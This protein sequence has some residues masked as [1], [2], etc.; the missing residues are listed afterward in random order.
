M[1]ATQKIQVGMIHAGKTVTV[2]AEDSQFPLVIDDETVTAV[3]RATTSEIHSYKAYATKTPWLAHPEG[4]KPQSP[5]SGWTPVTL[6]SSPNCCNSSPAGRPATP[7]GSARRW[8]VMSAIPPTAPRS[9]AGTWTGS[10]S[11]S[12]AT[13]ANPSLAQA[14]QNEARVTAAS[15]LRGPRAPK[16]AASLPLTL[17]GAPRRLRG[18]SSGLKG[19]ALRATACGRL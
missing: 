1:V 6:P 11:C 3:P 15:P 8:P 18:C 14:R 12:A 13:T 17:P 2:V 16:E 9:C 10:P 4:G 7:P 5:M 19:A